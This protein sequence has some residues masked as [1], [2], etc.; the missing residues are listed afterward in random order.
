MA[1]VAR[2]ACPARRVDAGRAVERI[3]REPGVVG[4]CRQRGGG[5]GGK[6]LDAGIVVQ[7][8]AG[9]RLAMED[10]PIDG[11]PAAVSGEQRPV[12]VERPAARKA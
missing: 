3:D 2:L 7:R 8:R 10:R 12:H 6:R 5:R 11:R 9:F 4:E 1:E